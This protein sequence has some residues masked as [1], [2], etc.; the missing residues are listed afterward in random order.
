MHRMITMSKKR[1][2]SS[3]GFTQRGTKKHKKRWR[4]LIQRMIMKQRIK[5]EQIKGKTCHLCFVK[6]IK[7][8]ENKFKI[9]QNNF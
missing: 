2:G 7:F 5:I 6:V 9:I 3:G 8:Q 4:A 1:A